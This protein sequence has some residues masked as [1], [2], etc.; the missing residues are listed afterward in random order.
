MQEPERCWCDDVVYK[1]RVPDVTVAMGLHVTVLMDAQFKLIAK[2]FDVIRAQFLLNAVPL[3][4]T[5][6]ML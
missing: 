3:N 6:Q 1:E 2:V 5:V 4:G